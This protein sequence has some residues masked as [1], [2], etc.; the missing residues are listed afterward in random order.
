MIKALENK[1]RFI[2]LRFF[3]N[4]ESLSLP[5]YSQQYSSEQSIYCESMDV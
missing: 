3:S 4:M 5:G 1:K 2:Y